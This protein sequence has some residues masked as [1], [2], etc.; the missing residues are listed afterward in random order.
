MQS[1]LISNIKTIERYT[2]LNMCQHL[3]QRNRSAQ[4]TYFLFSTTTT[5]LFAEVSILFS[6]SWWIISGAMNLPVRPVARSPMRLVMTNRWVILERSRS[7]S[8]T[9]FHVRRITMSEEWRKWSLGSDHKFW[10]PLIS[11][12]DS[13][14]HKSPKTKFPP[15]K[16]PVVSSLRRQ[17]D[18]IF[19]RALLL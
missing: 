11:I 2:M 10:E 9:K 12:Y 19:I 8:L 13:T 15:P 16:R 5:T 4:M 6:I 18:R 17:I 7:L 3:K 14:V 1:R